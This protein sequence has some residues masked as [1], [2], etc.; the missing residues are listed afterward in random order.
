MT[1]SRDGI[2]TRR[3]QGA[4][5]HKLFEREPDAL[6]IGRF[7][8]I[9]RLGAGGMGRV[10]R[11]YDPDLDRRVAV[12]VLLTAK[13]EDDKATAR[14][15]REART[16]AQL[17]H[18]NVVTVF[19]AGMFEG[20]VFVAMEYV[21]GGTLEE[22]MHEQ[23]VGT[24]SRREGAI[25]LAVQAAR[26]LAAA[27]EAGVVHRDLKPANMLIDATG[28]LRIADFGLASSRAGATPD[29]ADR[30]ATEERLTE[31]GGVMGTPAYMAP[32][33]QRGLADERS[34][35]FS[36]CVSFFEAVYGV[37]PYAGR[38]LMARL[39]SIER[40]D[41]QEPEIGREPM[42]LWRSLL[43]GLSPEPD[44]RFAEV[45][46][47]LAVLES[48]RRPRRRGT[49]ALVG[50]GVVAAVAAAFYAGQGDTQRCGD[51][52]ERLGDAWSESRRA[53]V[54][55]ALERSELPY[56]ASMAGRVL[57]V[58]DRYAES[59]SE[60]YAEACSA[61]WIRGEQS[62][63][64]LDLRMQCLDR[65]RA[66]LG[67]VGETLAAGDDDALRQ[68]VSLG[69]KLPDLAACADRETLQRRSEGRTL[70][71]ITA[72]AAASTKLDKGLVLRD[73]GRFEESD[74]L[75]VAVRED[76]EAHALP[77][78]VSRA[79]AHLSQLRADQ[80]RF[81]ESIE[82]ADAGLRAAQASRDGDVAAVAHL[83]KA[84]V[85]LNRKDV[86]ATRFHLDLA[87]AAIERGDS[88]PERP[89]QVAFM[90]G[91]VAGIVGDADE[92][93]RQIDRAFEIFAE[94]RG[95][96][97][98]DIGSILYTKG[99]ALAV[100]G[101]QNEALEVFL[102]SAAIVAEAYGDQ[103]PGQAPGLSG[104]GSVHLILGEPE[105]AL[106][107]DR[108]G[109]DLLAADPG[110]RPQLRAQA[111]LRIADEH[112]R[113][114]RQD[115]A[116]EWLDRAERV[117]NDVMGPDDPMTVYV[118]FSRG[119]ILLDSRRDYEGAAASF[120]NVIARW[121]GLEAQQSDTFIA[122]LNLAIA[123]SRAQKHDEAVT[124]ATEALA[125]AATTIDPDGQ[126]M[127]GYLSSFGD[128]YRLAGKR[129]EAKQAYSRAVEISDKHG[130][131]GYLI[132]E[133][134][135]GLARIL[136]QE[137]ER[138]RAKELAAV[139]R[140]NFEAGGPAKRGMLKELDAWEKASL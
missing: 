83:S 137:G 111:T 33:Q 5:E 63:R 114:G 57:A 71:Q 92:A 12:K 6:R 54:E 59:W 115:E 35:Q 10:Y 130:G 117:F 24:A 62:E 139:A 38:T 101:R 53:A 11:A 58:L 43:R 89:G 140:A 28:R 61:T 75:L 60:G 29:Y 17:N 127:I 68:A 112:N 110:Y 22:W 79:E 85:E 129:Q 18:P 138:A 91:D 72:A 125:A 16:M 122:R 4:L 73:I 84:R 67:F 108:R 37:T 135:F 42:W 52:Q 46:S 20:N 97:S 45:A 134:K 81:D 23:E 78:L 13:R 31:T 87:E 47:L 95:P 30:R 50:M 2:E 86:D 41:V 9:D 36:Y 116:L 105:K 25:E 7:L 27:H 77:E 103:H 40:G 15:L 109:Y 76:G 98:A 80:A 100:A 69:E 120:R 14:L 19:E 66:A 1:G 107:L 99:R 21:D 126:Q 44:D 74:A 88:P 64:T 131:G 32:E 93:V 96:N 90:R 94:S 48:N 55:A 56:S 124:S 70:E 121:D 26:G 65:G 113:L 3:L 49:I 136:L 39:E 118:E 102:Q 119:S 51:V 8:V 82:H 132:D 104:A 34:D 133:A 123:L 106:E 128:I